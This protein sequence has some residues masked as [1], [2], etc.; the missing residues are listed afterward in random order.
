MNASAVCFARH[1]GFWHSIGKQSGFRRILG[2]VMEPGP[3]SGFWD[4]KA[5]SVIGPRHQVWDGLSTVNG[6][7]Y[8]PIAAIGIG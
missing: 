4:G 7:N 1:D 8:A 5:V 6:T 3:L 2:R